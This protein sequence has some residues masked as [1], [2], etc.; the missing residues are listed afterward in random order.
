MD[1]ILLKNIDKLGDKHDVVKVKPGYANNYLIPK[2]VAVIANKDNLKKLDA[3]KADE[4]AKEAARL[5][6]YK[7]IAAKMEGQTLRIGVKAGTSGKIFG[8]ITNVQVVRALRE[9]LGLDIE[10]KKIHV[11]DDIKEVGTYKATVVLHKELSTSIDFNL[12]AE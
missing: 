6:E 12:V 1:I 5:E 7:V 3:L 8:S 4:E 11:A 10:R 9:Q 2:G